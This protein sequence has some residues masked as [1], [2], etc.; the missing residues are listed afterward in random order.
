MDSAR[1][2]DPPANLCQPGAG[3][4][5]QTVSVP[6]SRA[7]QAPQGPAAPGPQ[8]G[9]ATVT[10]VTVTQSAPAQVSQTPAFEPGRPTA[11]QG[12]M[13]GAPEAEELSRVEAG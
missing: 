12:Q 4:S 1:P 9:G 6:R 10:Q 2:F 7:P 13:A 3:R 5:Y 8:V 11:G